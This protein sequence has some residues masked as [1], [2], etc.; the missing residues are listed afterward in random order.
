MSVLKVVAGISG[1]FSDFVVE[2]ANKLRL[3]LRQKKA[4]GFKKNTFIRFPPNRE[5]FNNNQI[6]LF[7]SLIHI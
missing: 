3:R 4:T 7:L 6:L 5:Y 1:D 2:L